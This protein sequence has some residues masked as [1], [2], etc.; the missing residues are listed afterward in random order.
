MMEM[1]RRADLQ[2]EA[3]KFIL[4]L[5]GKSKEYTKL[6][7]NPSKLAALANTIIIEETGVRIVFDNV[8]QRDTSSNLLNK[9]GLSTR[10]YVRDNQ[11]TIEYSSFS[12]FFEKNP[13]K[14]EEFA[15]KYPNLNSHLQL[16]AKEA[17]Q[18]WEADK[19]RAAQEEQA[20]Q[21]R[22]QQ[23]EL[24]RRAHQSSA[25]AISSH[26]ATPHNSQPRVA[27]QVLQTPNLRADAQQLAAPQ[28]RAEAKSLP[29]ALG[30]RSRQQQV[31][32]AQQS[33]YERL[34][35][36]VLKGAGNPIKEFDTK[37]EDKNYI[38]LTFES[39]TTMAAARKDL[40]AAGISSEFIP[41][42][43]NNYRIELKIDDKA[44]ISLERMESKQAEARMHSLRGLIEIGV[45]PKDG[46]LSREI[47]KDETLSDKT[48]MQMLDLLFTN[49]L[50]LED[51]FSANASDT[52][53]KY[54]VH[55]LTK[56]M[57]QA[58]FNEYKQLPNKNAAIVSQCNWLLCH[59]PIDKAQIIKM[60]S[61]VTDPSE[62]LKTVSI[63]DKGAMSI[64]HRAI[65]SGAVDLVEVIIKKEKEL[66]EAKGLKY[67]DDK[68]FKDDQYQY[69]T[70]PSQTIYNSKHDDNTKIAMIRILVRNGVS[71][72]D[73]SSSNAS[74]YLK[75]QVNLL[76][77]TLAKGQDLKQMSRSAL[78]TPEG[79]KLPTPTITTH[80]QKRIDGHSLLPQISWKDQYAAPGA[81]LSE[82]IL[83]SKE[84]EGNFINP[85]EDYVVVKTSK[86]GKDCC[87]IYLLSD[88]K[89]MIKPDAKDFK[90]EYSN[91][92]VKISD[93]YKISGK[94]LTGEINL[95]AESNRPGSR[96]G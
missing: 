34:I 52:I 69:A 41:L 1:R 66:N 92:T 9:K 53:Q 57:Q 43:E 63:V 32:E 39:K 10:P 7:K 40:Q 28:Q 5:S 25:A 6:A 46:S 62:L 86:D 36:Q 30:Q 71:I 47:Y 24:K 68:R 3:I 75:H 67:S 51:P 95:I 4:E 70:H 15:R 61:E 49:G 42:R 87:S 21:A 38:G 12:G 8:S 72:E 2:N 77:A 29:S 16:K 84:G 82:Y 11:L 44:R 96:L 58:E 17:Q 90:D 76:R 91:T 94:N 26:L 55:L 50:K 37:Y 22:I 89:N 85:N 73:P 33:P 48:K 13:G 14:K 19:L 83:H 59:E 54:V 88:F 31:R 74:S 81:E 79:V 20:A 80:E 64:L 45:D 23:E 60:V 56:K 18:R 35:R 27:P 78:F 93:M 65:R